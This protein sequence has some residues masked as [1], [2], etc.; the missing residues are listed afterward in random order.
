MEMDWNQAYETGDFKNW[1]FGTASSE[2]VALFAVKGLP[3]EGKRAVD[4]GC[5][6]GW[7][8]IFLV[9]CGFDVTGIDFSSNAIQL[10]KKRAEDAKVQVDF[11]QGNALA[12]PVEDESIDFANDRGCLHVIPE[13]DRSR[14][15]K[16]ILRILKPGGQLLLRG[17]R[18]LTDEL[19]AAAGER[20]IAIKPLAKETIES[21]FSPD[22]FTLGPILPLRLMGETNGIPGNIVLITKR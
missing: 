19:K 4:I 21:L 3:P 7:E 22:H 15:V 11:K 9:K 12:L 14:Y 5:G 17:C 2:L 16:E 10:A 13:E 6:G 8:S 20:K 18:E 1:D